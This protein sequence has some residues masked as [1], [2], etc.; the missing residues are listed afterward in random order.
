VLVEQLRRGVEQGAAGGEP[1][2]LTRLSTRPNSVIV[3]AT[4]ARAW[5]TS[6]ASACT[7]SALLPAS[8]SSATSASPGSRRRPVTA[9][10]APSR[11]AARAMPARPGP[12]CRR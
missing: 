1:G 6:P 10:S 2:A 9:T 7:N 5:A 4:E 8:V 11:T 12:A 3:A